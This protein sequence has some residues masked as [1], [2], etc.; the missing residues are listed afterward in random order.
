MLC[1][2]LSRIFR[3]DLLAEASY[4]RL[5]AE[6]RNVG[7]LKSENVLPLKQILKPQYEEMARSVTA[8]I[9]AYAEAIQLTADR[10][11]TDEAQTNGYTCIEEILQ[12]NK[13]MADELRTLHRFEL[14]AKFD[15]L[16]ECILEEYDQSRCRRVLEWKEKKVEQLDR[17]LEVRETA[18]A[19]LAAEVSVKLKSHLPP[20]EAELN[21]LTIMRKSQRVQTEDALSLRAGVIGPLTEARATRNTSVGPT[22]SRTSQIAT[23]CWRACNTYDI[24]TTIV[25]LLRSTPRLKRCLDEIFGFFVC[26]PGNSDKAT[27][28]GTNTPKEPQRPMM[29][30]PVFFRLCAMLKLHPDLLGNSE[31]LSWLFEKFSVQPFSCVITP[32][33]FPRKMP[34]HLWLACLR[35]LAY[36]NVLHSLSEE[37]V[38]AEA[39]GGQ[40]AE[41]GVLETALRRLPAFHLFCK[42]HVIPLYRLLYSTQDFFA[43]TAPLIPGTQLDE[44]AS[45]T[46]TAVAP[47]ALSDVSTPAQNPK[48]QLPDYVLAQLELEPLQL[49]FV[50]Y[51]E[52]TSHPHLRQRHQRAKLDKKAGAPLPAPPTPT[53]ASRFVSCSIFCELTRDFGL[54]P[55]FLSLDAV[56]N[57]FTTT[58]NLAELEPSNKAKDSA[59]APPARRLDFSH[60][61]E[62]LVLSVCAGAIARESA[63]RAQSSTADV[64]S[65]SGSSSQQVADASSQQTLA[66]RREAL[67]LLHI[68]G[69]NDSHRVLQH[70]HRQLTAQE[71]ANL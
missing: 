68:C 34:Y 67:E 45:S 25:K 41:R 47:A 53:L 24:H 27:D 3:Y 10:L 46:E 17:V 40:A 1:R 31:R 63:A 22:T 43:H 26:H 50:Y 13:H 39:A 16:N 8:S 42:R 30:K 14:G 28:R 7:R 57:I 48:V 56:R 58:A 37:A 15:R 4:L 54:V 70:T 69:F 32:E 23:K 18:L 19:K 71:K 33:G 61:V 11:S 55:G 36:D 12:A 64:S 29:S 2:F 60:F 62:A 49:L 6:K 35:E 20:D 59:P 52:L 51:A 21:E 38:A 44:L 9:C 5:L 65:S 66:L